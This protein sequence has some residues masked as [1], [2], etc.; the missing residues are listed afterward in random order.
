MES[1]TG[2]AGC[3]GRAH[4][5]AH[6]HGACAG[7]DRFPGGVPCA[8]RCTAPFRSSLS[9][10]LGLRPVHTANPTRPSVQASPRWADLPEAWSAM[11]AVRPTRQPLGPVAMH[12]ATPG[13]TE[14]ARRRGR[15]AVRQ[16]A[17]AAAPPAAMAEARRAAMAEAR[18]AA[19][20]EARRAAMAAAAGTVE[21]AAARRF[22]R[23]GPALRRITTRE[24]PAPAIAAVAWQTPI[25]PAVA[26]RPVARRRVATT[27]TTRAA[28]R[29]HAPAAGDGRAIPPTTVT[30]GAIAAVALPTPIARAAVAPRPIA[31]TLLA[32]TAVT[33]TAAAFRAV[34]V[35]EDATIPAFGR[36]TACA[37][38][39]G[40]APRR[41]PAPTARIAPI[42]VRAHSA[43]RFRYTLSQT[44]SPDS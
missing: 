19:M 1:L 6:C 44:A 11:L 40:L 42:A 43:P 35:P 16:E 23:V 18:R 36:R 4:F 39:A 31:Q 20:A 10:A 34:G 38:T 33:V 32:S 37:T 28:R 30:V 5:A 24:C 21:Q 2:W 9:Q 26:H 12:R 27:A 3:F 15:E 25:A 17:T 41:P 7:L 13:G 29:F 8:L 14:T 22:P